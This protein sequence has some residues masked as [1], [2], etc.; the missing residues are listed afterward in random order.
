[1]VKAPAVSSGSNPS[2]KPLGKQHGPKLC[3]SLRAWEHKLQRG[4]NRKALI[5]LA[6]GMKSK[7]KGGCTTA[8]ELGVPMFPVFPS[9]FFNGL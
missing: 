5:L 9:D 1:M 4:H 2:V 7:E 3:F 6:L 8:I